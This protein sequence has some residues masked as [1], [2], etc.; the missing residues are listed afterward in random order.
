MCGEIDLRINIG[1]SWFGLSSLID[2]T[3][4]CGFWGGV[5]VELITDISSGELST[6][7]VLSLSK[8]CQAKHKGEPD[9]EYWLNGT[10]IWE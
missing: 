4:L 2:L 9:L 10:K 3:P 6:P 7:C 1:T 8:Q 5:D